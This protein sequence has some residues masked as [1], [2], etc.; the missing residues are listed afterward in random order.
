MY[1]YAYSVDMLRIGTTAALALSR[2]QIMMDLPSQA[3]LELD[4]ANTT[5][6]KLNARITEL[7]QAASGLQASRDDLL[8]QL[9]TLQQVNRFE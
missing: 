3:L 1:Q 8:A 5:E 2:S 6:V 7:E 4:I 9:H